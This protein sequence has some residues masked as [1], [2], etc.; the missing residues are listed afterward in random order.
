[1][2]D[3]MIR[4]KK[5]LVGLVVVCLIVGV[6]ITTLLILNSQQNAAY[7]VVVKGEKVPAG[8][9]NYFVNT[10]RDFLESKAKAEQGEKFDRDQFLSSKPGGIPVMEQAKRDGLSKTKEFAL[11]IAIAKREKIALSP[12]E[13]AQIDNRLEGSYKSNPQVARKF[14]DEKQITMTDLKYINYGEAIIEKLK[15]TTTSDVTITD[16]EV[17]KYYNENQAKFVT[18]EAVRISLIWLKTT[19]QTGKELPADQMAGVRDKLR[20]ITSRIKAG[21]EFATLAKEFSEDQSSARNGGD[22]GY[23]NRGMM[24]PG[25]EQLIFSMK[26]GQISEPLQSRHGFEIIK[27]LD[28]QKPKQRT[29]DDLKADLKL[30]LL[31]GKKLDRYQTLLEEWKKQP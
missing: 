8:V 21:A 24:P 2:E 18:Q 3:I 11:Q 4:S 15:T 6:A 31:E 14:F 20:R 29:Y 5:I 19:D 13:I 10:A 26:P 25:M 12:A 23:C 1:M 9:L 7:P 30:R 22:L 17:E 28:K 27:L 16:A